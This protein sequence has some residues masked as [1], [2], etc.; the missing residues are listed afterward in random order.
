MHQTGLPPQQDD[1][2]LF[3]SHLAKVKRRAVRLAFY[4][5]VVPYRIVSYDFEFARQRPG[6]SSNR[7]ESVEIEAGFI[8]RFLSSSSACLLSSLSF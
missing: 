3:L 7:I 4:C 8:S 1:T 6:E 5:R 2:C